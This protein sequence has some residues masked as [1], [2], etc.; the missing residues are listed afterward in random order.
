M[1][2]IQRFLQWCNKSI[3]AWLSDVFQSINQTM[4]I[5][6]GILQKIIVFVWERISEAKRKV[7]SW[8]PGS[9]YNFSYMLLKLNKDD[10]F[11]P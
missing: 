3:S 7:T 8:T 5:Q 11:R 10:S 9:N 2:M 4:L 6:L 1:S